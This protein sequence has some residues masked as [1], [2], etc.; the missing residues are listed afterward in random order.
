MGLFY[1]W[2][3]RRESPLR[4]AVV[5]MLATLGYAILALP[6]RREN[7]V[8]FLIRLAPRRTR[9]QSMAHQQQKSPDGAVLLLVEAAGIEPASR[10]SPPSDLH[11]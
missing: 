7:A 9:F 2:W 3:R 5:A 10:N 8:R 6:A 4:I 1:Y 11:V